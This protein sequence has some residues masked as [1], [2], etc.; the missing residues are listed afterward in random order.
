MFIGS[1][2]LLGIQ[3]IISIEQFVEQKYVRET[4]F[5]RR[6]FLDMF[7][8]CAFEFLQVFKQ[9]AVILHFFGDRYQLRQYRDANYRISVRSK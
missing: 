5:K 8:E 6:I 9:L 7:I 3:V 2:R 1:L 4:V